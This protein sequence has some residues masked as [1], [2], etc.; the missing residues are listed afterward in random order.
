MTLNRAWTLASFPTEAV[1]EDNFKL[2]EAPVP[3]PREGE[4]LVKNLWLSLDPYMRG[5][6]SQ[7]KSYAKGVEIG[8]VMTG[9]TAG[10]VVQSKHPKFAPGDAVTAPAGW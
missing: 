7:Q 2:I 1:R 4:V 5:R 8:E 6:I 9:E 3:V 10:E